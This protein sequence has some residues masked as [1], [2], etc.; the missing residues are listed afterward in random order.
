MRLVTPQMLFF[1]ALLS[2][3]KSYKA[4]LSKSHF[5]EKPFYYILIFLF[6]HKNTSQKP[7]LALERYI[8]LY[9]T[10]IIII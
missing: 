2:E 9:Y 5:M 4:V 3:R 7:K 8:D 10:Y 6:Y 1:K